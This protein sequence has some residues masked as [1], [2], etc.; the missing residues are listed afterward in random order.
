MVRSYCVSCGKVVSERPCNCGKETMFCPRCGVD[1]RQIVLVYC[2]K[3]GE[4]IKK[5]CAI[6]GE[7]ITEQPCGCMQENVPG[8]SEIK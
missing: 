5:V 2:E 8:D 6:C 7:T 1:E 4:L 3:C